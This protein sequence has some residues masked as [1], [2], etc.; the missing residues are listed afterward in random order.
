M[1]FGSGG[2][3]VNPRRVPGGEEV[4]MDFR[5][6]VLLQTADEE[7][8]RTIS[9]RPNRVSALRDGKTEGFINNNMNS[10]RAMVRT[11]PEGSRVRFGGRRA[12][13]LSCSRTPQTQQTRKNWSTTTGSA[14]FRFP[15]KG[16]VRL[17]GRTFCRRRTSSRVSARPSNRVG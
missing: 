2:D 3:D 15:A 10:R 13:G 6:S 8:M 5:V 1:R 4:L 9:V 11:A 14:V 17:P 16:N 12:G 7:R